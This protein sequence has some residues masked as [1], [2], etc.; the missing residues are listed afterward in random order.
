M[1][2]YKVN[3]NSMEADSKTM[4][5]ILYHEWSIRQHEGDM[6]KIKAGSSYLKMNPLFTYSNAILLLHMKHE[7]SPNCWKLILQMKLLCPSSYWRVPLE[8]KEL[9]FLL[10]KDRYTVDTNFLKWFKLRATDE[11]T[12][13]EFLDSNPSIQE[14]H[15]YLQ[16]TYWFPSIEIPYEGDTLEEEY[17]QFADDLDDWMM[18]FNTNTIALSSKIMKDAMETVQDSDNFQEDLVMGNTSLTDHI[19]KVLE[20]KNIFEC[21]EF[22]DEESMEEIT[23]ESPKGELLTERFKVIL[24]SAFQRDYLLNSDTM[25]R[26]KNNMRSMDRE[27]ACKS[28]HRVMYHQLK[29]LLVERNKLYLKDSFILTLTQLLY[30]KMTDRMDARIK[31]PLMQRNITEKMRNSEMLYRKRLKETELDPILEAFE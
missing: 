21:M 12:V 4:F 17:I 5:Q 13:Y 31:D 19:G 2:I 28:M 29:I 23:M 22:F 15:N 11:M 26:L 18:T 16:N 9:D 3:E 1:H 27:K 6:V 14:I 20:M 7:M 8:L 25:S 30:R 24:E 10:Y